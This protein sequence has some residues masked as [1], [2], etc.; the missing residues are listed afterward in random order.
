MV[1]SKI[2]QRFMEKSPVPV[3]VQVLLERVLNADKLNA[4]FER[5]AVEQ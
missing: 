4:L 2:F 5:V 1:F 3:M